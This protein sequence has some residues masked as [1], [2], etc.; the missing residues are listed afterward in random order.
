[1]EKRGK[2]FGDR[3]AG[4]V[5]ESRFYPMETGVGSVLYFGASV[6]IAD[7]VMSDGNTLEKVGVK[8][9]EI[10][11]PSGEDLAKSKDPVLSK[12]AKELGVEISPEKAGTLFPIKWGN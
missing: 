2:V 3:T 4:A 9:D 12:A 7:L 8:P 5:M 10:A 1:M 6:T 11:L